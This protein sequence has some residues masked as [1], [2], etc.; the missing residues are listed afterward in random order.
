MPAFQRESHLY[1]VTCRI[2]GLEGMKKMRI[3]H[4]KNIWNILIFRYTERAVY[5]RYLRICGFSLLPRRIEHCTS[6]DVPVTQWLIFQMG[7]TYL[8]VLRRVVKAQANIIDKEGRG[9]RVIPA[10]SRKERDY[11]GRMV[12]I[13]GHASLPYCI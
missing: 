10:K 12:R 11:I 8:A 4:E 9:Y 6:Q 7:A 3:I 13:R 2:F 5:C 1:L